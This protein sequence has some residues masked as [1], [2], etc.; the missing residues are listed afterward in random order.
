[1]MNKPKAPRIEMPRLLKLALDN[2]HQARPPRAVTQGDEITIYVHGVI[3]QCWGDVDAQEFTKTLA[4]S[5]ANTLHLR[6]N[7]PGGD[8]FDA[9]SM[10][11]AISQFKG[12]TIAHIDGVAASAA[13]VIC[14]ACNEVE[15][16]QGANFMIHNA[17]T[18]AMG[19]KAD[20]AKTMKL[21]EKTDEGL[22]ADYARRSGQPKDTIRQWMDDETW[23]SADEAL[24]NRFADRVVEVVDDLNA[25]RTWDLSAYSHAP[26]HLTVNTLKKEEI[27]R[28]ILNQMQARERRLKLLQTARP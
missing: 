4:D 9:R 14:M 3:S 19:N 20:M 13:T 28:D 12:K 7:S 21:L 15:I 5:T 24:N 2:V 23:F 26:P 6:I 22:V 18:L 16:A 17:W 25:H 10:M 1:M 8:V 27:S 11:T